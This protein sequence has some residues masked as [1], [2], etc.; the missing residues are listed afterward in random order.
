MAQTRI[1]N[2]QRNAGGEVVD[3]HETRIDHDKQT[4]WTT[5]NYPLF[6]DLREHQVNGK[7][8]TLPLWEAATSLVQ[9][10]A[11]NILRSD[12]R[13]LAFS[14]FAEMPRTFSGFTMFA[15]SNKPEE[16][17]LRD[18]TI[19]VLPPVKSGEDFP[20]LSTT[21][22]GS[23]NIV[24]QQYG[25]LFEIPMDYVRFDQIGK[26]RQTASSMG[27][28]ARMTEEWKVYD[29][30]TTTGNYTRNS[31]TDDNDIGANTE[32]ATFNGTGLEK[33]MNVIS[34]SKDRKSGAPLGYKA[35]TIVIG[36]RMEIPVKMLLLSGDLHRTHGN[37]TSE[38]RGTG[39]V[40]QYR[41]MIDNIIIS[42]WFGAS[43]QWALVDSS[44][45]S[46]VFQTVESFNVVQ[47]SPQLNS[48]A[49]FTADKIRW[50]VS[51]YFGLGFVDDRAWYYSDSTTP[52]TIA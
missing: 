37:T 46:F 49:W 28:A 31:T 34:T 14:R 9:P 24:N 42:P 43:Y 25:G 27:R 29:Y 5:D 15:D 20:I 38:I 23:A 4:G 10:D 33:G 18:A 40:N 26:I 12:I 2:L 6:K 3:M 17:W 8:V 36:P 51:G 48:E 50:R 1:I 32:T 39:T 52:P 45:E 30:V 11:A 47:E 44:V 22:E 7:K 41:G 19:G 21:F 13:F 16:S 35:D